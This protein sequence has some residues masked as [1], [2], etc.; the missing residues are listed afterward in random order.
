MDHTDAVQQMT[1]ERYLLEEL[2]PEERNRFEEH[3][4]DCPECALDLRAGAAFVDEAKAQL[5][6]LEAK[7]PATR[8]GTPKPRG[9]WMLTTAV[10]PVPLPETRTVGGG[11]EAGAAHRIGSEGNAA[12]AGGKQGLTDGDGVAAVVDG[13]APP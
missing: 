1:A 10:A 5:P 7:Q 8:N 13:C 12:A 4:F 6:E 3:A 11:V 2:T 9:R